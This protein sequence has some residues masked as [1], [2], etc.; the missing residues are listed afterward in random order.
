MKNNKYLAHLIVKG[1]KL[2]FY[3]IITFYNEILGNIKKIIIWLFD[4]EEQNSLLSSL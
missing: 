4:D 3:P 2:N 1:I